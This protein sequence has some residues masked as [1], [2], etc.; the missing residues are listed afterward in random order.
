MW[1]DRRV[2]SPRARG[3]VAHALRLSVNYFAHIQKLVAEGHR[4]FE[5]GALET[6]ESARLA[7]I[8][9]ELDQCWICCASDARCVKQG[10]TPLRLT[11][12]RAKLS[13]GISGKPRR[14]MTIR[15]L[16]DFEPGQEFGSGG[17]V[18]RLCAHKILRRRIRS[19]A[20]SFGR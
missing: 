1:R 15:Y 3:W 13:R 7:A 5:N 14:I 10:A 6:S 4:L 17:T 12:A 19:T 11:F 16:E 18:C 9:V 20:S 8:Q 2:D